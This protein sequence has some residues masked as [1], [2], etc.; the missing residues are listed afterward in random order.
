MTLEKNEDD[1]LLLCITG[2]NEIFMK[3]NYPPDFTYAD[4]V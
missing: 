3:D 2:M 4:F 1:I